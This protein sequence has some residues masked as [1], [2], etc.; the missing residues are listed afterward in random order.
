MNLK[1][2]LLFNY[3]NAV[4]YQMTAHQCDT[5]PKQ[6]PKSIVLQC[7][8]LNTLKNRANESKREKCERA[9]CC[10][11]KF[12]GRELCWTNK[13]TWENQKKQKIRLANNQKFSGHSAEDQSPEPVPQIPVATLQKLKEQEDRRKELAIL[14]LEEAEIQAQEKKIIEAE[15]QEIESE[16]NQNLGQLQNNDDDDEENNNNNDLN[17][18]EID[19][20]GE[21]RVSH[22]VNFGSNTEET[23]M[24]IKR[25]DDSQQCL[26]RIQQLMSAG[27]TQCLAVVPPAER[28]LCDV[29]AARFSNPELSLCSACLKSNCCY[30]PTPRITHGRLTPMCYHPSSSYQTTIDLNSQIAQDLIAATTTTEA[31]T[32]LSPEEEYSQGIMKGHGHATVAPDMMGNKYQPKRDNRYQA[33]IQQNYN[34]QPAN[35]E[36]E[37]SV[38]ISEAQ[39]KMS[40]ML[41]DN[42]R[43]AGKF[44]MLG[45]NVNKPVSSGP[46][47]PSASS[48]NNYSD[49]MKAFMSMHGT[50]KMPSMGGF[51]SSSSSPSSSNAYMDKIRAQFMGSSGSS[52][53]SS[54]SSGSN[55]FGASIPGLNKMELLQSILGGSKKPSSSISA[56]AVLSKPVEKEPEFTSKMHEQM[57][58]QLMSNFENNLR[59][60]GKSSSA[61]RSTR[62]R[63]YYLVSF[64][65]IFASNFFAFH[66]FTQFFLVLRD[67]K[68]HGYLQENSTQKI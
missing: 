11:N 4:H 63:V 47:A 15:E 42:P 2:I 44:G 50:S 32:T 23:M 68:R 43:L 58:K 38:E 49:R 17:P 6:K 28:T 19:E 3:A 37:Q 48:S 12:K 7:P 36:A 26:N 33:W 56:P 29:R 21:H 16:I 1:Y 24:A 9:G 67:G 45:L 8:L 66:I 22:L 10:F 25:Q 40:Q 5:I 54:S 52:L 60:S 51:S 18:I 20:D 46:A 53:S 34:T 35:N 64:F 65:L 41:K 30:D 39:S 62:K 59:L 31:T 14:A 61:M 27:A 13:S 55:P 57:Y